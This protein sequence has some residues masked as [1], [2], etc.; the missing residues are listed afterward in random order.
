MINLL[1]I[2]NAF[3]GKIFFLNVC[4][5]NILHRFYDQLIVLHQSL[6]VKTQVLRADDKDQNGTI[7]KTKLNLRSQNEDDDNTYD[8]IAQLFQT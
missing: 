3:R 7:K 8:D 1:I 4:E 6:V 2:S 5:T